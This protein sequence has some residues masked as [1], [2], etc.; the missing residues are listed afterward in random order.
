MKIHDSNFLKI[1]LLFKAIK[2]KKY[3]QTT[4]IC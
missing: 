2:K 1:N 3:H 4:E